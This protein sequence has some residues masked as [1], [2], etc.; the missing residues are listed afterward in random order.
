MCSWSFLKLDKSVPSTVPRPTTCCAL[1]SG[2]SSWPCAWSRASSAACVTIV[3]LSLDSHCC[4][5][6]GYSV[7]TAPQMKRRGKQQN[8]QP[9]RSQPSC[10][11]FLIKKL[12]TTLCRM[13]VGRGHLFTAPSA[14]CG[15]CYP[16]VLV[17]PRRIT[18]NAIERHRK[19]STLDKTDWRRG[20]TPLEKLCC[21]SG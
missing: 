7:R 21:S 4:P 2:E 16:P 10:G 1:G 20:K 19:Q 6:M 3:I 12:Q 18:V 14:G 15:C 13:V 5:K 17:L 11:K 8:E 9:N